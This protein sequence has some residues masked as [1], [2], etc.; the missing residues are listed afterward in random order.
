MFKYKGVGVVS[1]GGFITDYLQLKELFINK[2]LYKSLSLL[3]AAELDVMILPTM[4][5]FDYSDPLVCD[6]AKDWGLPL[7]IR[8]DYSFFPEKK[9]LGGVPLYSIEKIRKVSS[10]LFKENC[11]PIL[12]P[13]IERNEDI[14]SVGVLLR[15][16]DDV[17][18]FEIVG[19]GFD[20]SDLRLG[21]F[22][23]HETFRYDLL[24]DNVTERYIVSPADYEK[25]R[26]EKC[27]KVLAYK[28][29][30]DYVNESGTLLSSISEFIPSNYL[31]YF[32]VD[33]LPEQYRPIPKSLIKSLIPIVFSIKYEMAS[34]LPY[35]EY[36]VVS[37]SY[38]YNYGWL[39]WDVY[40]E[41]YKR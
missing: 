31:K 41:W 39:L 3:C 14:Y 33:I 10:F 38:T 37:L 22:S 13:N 17:V 34:A 23:P 25:Q 6:I 19:Q 11:V 15:K 9:T 21:A 29:Y 18:L 4:V 12:H 32:D 30:V 20:A 5:I 16:N 2:K 24:S 36:Y 7:M 26:K 1:D 8:M 27:K 40:G 35:S 28:N